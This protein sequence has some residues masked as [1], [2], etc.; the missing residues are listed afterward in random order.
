MPRPTP[1]P[2]ELFQGPFLASTADRLGVSRKTLRGGRFRTLLRGVY[3]SAELPVTLDLR[4]RAALLVLPPEAAL[5]CW[6]AAALRDLPIPTVAR[7]DTV[8]AVV[9]HRSRRPRLLGLV[10]HE[11]SSVGRARLA[12]HIV[13][14]AATTFLECGGCGYREHV[15]GD[16]TT[17][18]LVDLVILGDAMVRHGFVTPEGLRHAANHGV[19]GWQPARGVRLLRPASALVRARVD[20]PMET[21][22]RLLMLLGGLP[23]PETGMEIHNECGGWVATVD[24]CFPAAK[25]VIEYDGDLHRT[26]RRK[27][28]HDVLT[29]DLLRNDLGWEIIVLTADDITLRPEQALERIHAAL[30]RRGQPG[31][32]RALDAGWRHYFDPDS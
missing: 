24:M 25:V 12:R 23:C 16:P 4:A 6:T 17:P 1:L 13:T 22:V 2:P 27:W 5:S 32:P 10:V 11:H 8:H 26:E 14:P 9:P 15:A 7:P 20:S 18:G 29:R 28:R 19:D 31:T 21:R 30:R 3:A